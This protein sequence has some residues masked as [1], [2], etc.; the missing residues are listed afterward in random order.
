VYSKRPSLYPTTIATQ[1]ENERNN[2]GMN[3]NDDPFADMTEEQIN[4]RLRHAAKDGR[5]AG[6]G[7]SPA[8]EPSFSR[9]SHGG[10]GGEMDD[11]FSYGQSYGDDAEDEEWY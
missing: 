5:H 3:Y 9:R 1:L 6:G 10:G 8:S 2:P 11:G 7:G 4:E